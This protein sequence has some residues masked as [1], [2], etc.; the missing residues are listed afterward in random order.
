[1]NENVENIS[2]ESLVCSAIREIISHYT[3]DEAFIF[4]LQ[5]KSLT[6]DII[7]VMLYL[8][9]ETNDKAQDSDENFS[10]ILLMSCNHLH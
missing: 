8:R 2:L 7:I 9:E 10:H 4:V 6:F 3:L 1:M 5:R